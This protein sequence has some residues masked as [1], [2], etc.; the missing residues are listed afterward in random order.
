LFSVILLLVPPPP[1]LFSSSNTKG[2]NVYVP[3]NT[4][5]FCCLLGREMI[6]K[7]LDKRAAALNVPLA[8]NPE[9][10]FEGT[11]LAEPI[12]AVFRHVIEQNLLKDPLFE[13][14]S[15]ILSGATMALAKLYLSEPVRVDENS[16]AAG[17]DAVGDAIK[18]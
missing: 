3:L 8:L 11:P 1:E 16:L 14:L 4:F 9:Q 13:M 12:F 6:E 2:N 5:T 15:A 10:G 7:V 17:L 18:R